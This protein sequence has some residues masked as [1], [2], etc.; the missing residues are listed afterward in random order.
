M[1]HAAQD[2]KNEARRILR[3][4]WPVVMAS[5]N[6]TLLQLTDV[7][8]VGAT[9]T[10]EVA[11]FGGSRAVTFITLMAAIGW[12]SGVLVFAAQADGAG[13]KHKTGDDYRQSLVLGATIGLAGGGE[14][15]KGGDV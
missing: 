9:G 3:L 6:W 13:D 8:V 14:K 7:V 5:L 4:A 11:G 12:M 15:H 1:D 10:H 2:W